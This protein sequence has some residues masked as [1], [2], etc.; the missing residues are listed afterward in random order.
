MVIFRGGGVLMLVMVAVK[1]RM[2]IGP[3]AMHIPT[4]A[5]VCRIVRVAGSV[6]IRVAPGRVRVDTA[7]AAT[8]TNTIANIATDRFC[9]S[10]PVR[11]NSDSS[12][13]AT[14]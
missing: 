6:L 3:M 8:P 2:V 9:P 13:Q 5:G 7:F 4:V 11:V 12:D 10:A 1:M 14:P